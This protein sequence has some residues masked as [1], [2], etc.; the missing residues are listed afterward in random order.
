M[1]TS[2][3]M[4]T[5]M[6]YVHTCSHEAVRLCMHD[7][8]HYRGAYPNHVTTP[9]RWAVPIRA[10]SRTAVRAT[11]TYVPLQYEIIIE[12]NAG[13]RIRCGL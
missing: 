6:R 4:D 10:A 2:V 11:P 13:A 1:S 5:R 12:V 7:L 8:V 9:N 3:D